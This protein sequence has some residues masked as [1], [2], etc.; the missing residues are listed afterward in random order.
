MK[1][2]LRSLADAVGSDFLPKPGKGLLIALVACGMLVG[3][4]AQAW[5][6]EDYSVAPSGTGTVTDPYQMGSLGNLVWLSANLGKLTELT[7]CIQTANIDAAPAAAWPQGFPKI[8]A[9]NNVNRYIL[10]V[11]DGQGYTVS[12][13]VMKAYAFAPD[14]NMAFFGYLHGTTI[15]NLGLVNVNIDGGC[16]DTGGLCGSLQYGGVIEDCYVTGRITALG[17]SVGA[18]VGYAY[19]GPRIERSWALQLRRD[20]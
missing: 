18:L 10:K 17:G 4:T 11:Y 20:E 3:S 5:K 8:T 19:N 7:Y 15:R 12:N 16:Q 13:L 14:E 1:M 2:F 6:I 9:Q